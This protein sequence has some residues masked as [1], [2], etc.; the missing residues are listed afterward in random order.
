MDS[1]HD[2]K[3]YMVK[4]KTVKMVGV[5]LDLN[6]AVVEFLCDP[7]GSGFSVVDAATWVAAVVQVW[8]LAQELPHAMYVW[9]AVGGQ[10]SSCEESRRRS[11]FVVSI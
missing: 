2:T 3:W 7:V 9:V 6:A 4:I 11:Y 1:L 10:H 8:S 5:S